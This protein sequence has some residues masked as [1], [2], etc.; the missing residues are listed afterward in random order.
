MIDVVAVALAAA[1]V[2]C[3]YFV[4]RCLFCFFIVQIDAREP[5]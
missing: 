1:V 3:L 5:F 2:Q 4:E